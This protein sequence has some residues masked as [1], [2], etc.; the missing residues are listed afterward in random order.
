MSTKHPRTIPSLA[1]VSKD[2]SGPLPV[3]LLDEWAAGNHSQEAARAL[4]EPFRREGFAVSSDTAGLTKMTQ[5]RDLL[6]VLWLV[7]EPKQIIHAVG[8]SI[9]GEAIGVWSADNTEMFYPVMLGADAVVDAMVEAQMRI[10]ERAQVKV[11]LCVHAGVF[12]EIGGGLYGREAQSV[13]LLAETYARGSEILVTKELVDRL[14]AP[15]EYALLRRPELDEI[16]A[17]GVFSLASSRRL[18]TLFEPPTIHPHPFPSEFF[19]ML[20]ERKCGP[21]VPKLET[22]TYGAQQRDCFVVFVSRHASDASEGD[23]ALLLDGL[24]QNERIATIVE[25]SVDVGA[26]VAQSGGGISILVFD[27]GAEAL[28]CARALRDRFAKERVEV[29]IGIDRGPVLLF[30]KGASCSGS[31][32]GDPINLS[33]KISEDLGEP[34]RISITERAAQSIDGIAGAAP[35]AEVISGV[36]VRGVIV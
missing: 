9:G 1:D 22:R 15:A 36:Q 8:T 23:L 11:G 13:E 2:I 3:G 28:T 4:L 7:S 17:S 14:R 10:A 34:G 18:P 6:D 24:V 35:F 20:C 16:H 27:S 25:D 5:E 31:I 30:L 32:A 19:A 26:H 21:A 33:S 12:Y 29:T